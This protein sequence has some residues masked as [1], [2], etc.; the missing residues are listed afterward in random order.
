MPVGGSGLA[1]SSAG[2]WADLNY[3]PAPC[4]LLL[5]AAWPWTQISLAK[6]CLVQDSSHR[7]HEAILKSTYCKL[8]G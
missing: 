3:N 6:A 5:R 2:S 4:F 8:G 1:N 7:P